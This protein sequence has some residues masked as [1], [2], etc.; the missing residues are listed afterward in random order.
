MPQC[1][2]QPPFTLLQLWRF[3]APGLY[4]HGRYNLR[5]AIIVSL[6]LFC[7]GILFCFYLVLPFM[8]SIAS[9]NRG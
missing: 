5:H 1:L 2:A 7:L 6:L 3:I 8:L 4:N 9:S